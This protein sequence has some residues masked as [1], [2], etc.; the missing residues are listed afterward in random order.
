[1]NKYIDI[2]VPVSSDLPHWP[3]APKV[4]F[5][6]RL[7]LAQGDEATD[8][9][10]F[11]NIH[12]GTHVDAPAHFI[13]G[14]KTVEALPL[15][16]LIGPVYVARVPSQT[17]AIDASTLNGLNIPENAIRVLLHTDNSQLWESPKF[18]PNFTA[19]TADGAEWLVQGGIRLIGID[20]LSIQRFS[21]TP[22]THRILLG[23]E[24]IIIEGLNLSEVAVGWYE[25]ICLPIKLQGLEGAPA[26]VLLKMRNSI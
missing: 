2:T 10:L 8:S 17:Q 4:R 12:T 18:Y 9:N 21:D 25:L 24:V 19:V 20:Y 26:R 13:A 11:M 3:D 15:D 7:D 16:I 5:E 23:A 1:M 14:G 22:D 6:H